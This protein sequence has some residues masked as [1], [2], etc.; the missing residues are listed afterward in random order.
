MNN[1]ANF[2]GIDAID[3]DSLLTDKQWQFSSVS[4]KTLYLIHT[5]GKSSVKLQNIG[6]IT[7]YLKYVELT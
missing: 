2:V 7:D 5:V 4:I 3:K 1:L 6:N